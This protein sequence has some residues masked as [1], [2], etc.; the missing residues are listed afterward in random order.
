MASTSKNI[1]GTIG[2]ETEHLVNIYDNDFNFTT[3]NVISTG[4]ILL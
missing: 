3:T 1:L 4:M 2:Q